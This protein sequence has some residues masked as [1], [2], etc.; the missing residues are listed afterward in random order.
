ML[1]EKKK[2]TKQI[3]KQMIEDNGIF[4]RIYIQRKLWIL[5]EQ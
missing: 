3:T 1:S 5:T 2:K 4:K